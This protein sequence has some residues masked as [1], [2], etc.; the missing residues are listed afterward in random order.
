MA[1][2]RRRSAGPSKRDA[3]DGPAPAGSGGFLGPLGI[4][5]TGNGLPHGPTAIVLAIIVAIVVYP[6]TRLVR[7]LTRR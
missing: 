3:D 4:Y 2:R 5:E 7:A 1:K 6:V